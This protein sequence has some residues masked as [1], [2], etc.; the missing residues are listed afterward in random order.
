M[1]RVLSDRDIV[2]D[3]FGSDAMRARCL[4]AECGPGDGEASSWTAELMSVDGGGAV[5]ATETDIAW[6][7]CDECAAFFGSSCYTPVEPTPSP[8]PSSPVPTS[9]VDFGAALRVSLS[10][11]VSEQRCFARRCAGTD[12]GCT[13]TAGGVVQSGGGREHREGILL[14]PKPLYARALWFLALS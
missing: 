5:L 10:L 1:Q 13:G 6:R 4:Q 8:P 2:I 9:S 3:T 12:M 14:L 11:Q 7:E